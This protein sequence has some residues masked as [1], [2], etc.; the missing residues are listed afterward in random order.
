MTKRYNWEQWELDIMFERYEEIGPSGIQALTQPR[1]RTSISNKAKSLGLSYDFNSWTEKEDQIVIDN[2]V[3]NITAAQVA[4]MLPGR[5]KVAVERR[6][7]R[8]GLK[9]DSYAVWT[10]W[11]VGIMEQH[12]PTMS[13]ESLHKKYLQDKTVPQIKVKAQLMALHKLDS[14]KW[15]AARNHYFNYYYWRDGVTTPDHAV[16]LGYLYADGNVSRNA[17]QLCASIKDVSYLDNIAKCLDYNGEATIIEGGTSEIVKQSGQQARYTF[18]S[19]EMFDDLDKLGIHPN[20][21]H[22]MEFPTV[23][24]IP[25]QFLPDFIRG[26]LEGDG[27]IYHSQ[28]KNRYTPDYGVTFTSVQKEFLKN[29]QSVIN[30][31][32]RLDCGKI[33]QHNTAYDLRYGGNQQVARIGQWMYQSYLDGYSTFVMERKFNKFVELW[34]QIS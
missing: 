34:K 10:D 29:I 3:D 27:S 23:E 2:W 26:F 5:T 30:L 15:Q 9:K 20:K 12:Y 31:G 8:L 13:N 22:D 7:Q 25:D 21:T 1:S 6:I 19:K 32:N 11:E 4:K 16:I 17:L 24:Q 14:V 33:R 18:Y 28:K